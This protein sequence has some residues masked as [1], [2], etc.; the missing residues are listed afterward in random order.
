M[1]SM[2]SRVCISDN[3]YMINK[4]SENLSYIICC[5]YDK[6]GYYTNMCLKPRKNA[7]ASNN[8]R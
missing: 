1:I 4:D 8:Q 6:K 3:I 5:N 2:P 7:E